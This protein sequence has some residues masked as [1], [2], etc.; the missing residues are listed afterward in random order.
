MSLIDRVVDVADVGYDRA[1]RISR[2]GSSTH[3]ARKLATSRNV[4]CASPDYQ[5]E[6]GTP[7]TPADLAQH[8]CIV[9]AY[10]GAEWHLQ[11][12]A[13]KPH[14]VRVRSTMQANNGDTARIA[15]LGGP[16]IIRRP[17]FLVGPDLRA[18]RL[19]PLLPGCRVPD[20][21]V[22]AVYPGRRHL[23]AK[24]RAMLDFLAEESSGTPP[25]DRD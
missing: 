2:A 25:W 7:A 24:V 16:G 6:H 19:V 15:A 5:R 22:L 18:G 20:I 10:V 23:S 13:G 1:I 21:D 8:A 9:Y 12:A 11:D 4:V 3:A 17:T 14:G